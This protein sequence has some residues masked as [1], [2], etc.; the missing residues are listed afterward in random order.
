[1]VKEFRF[2]ELNVSWS[3]M[4]LLKSSKRQ[5]LFLIT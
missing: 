5:L 1:M 2:K 3:N 4:P